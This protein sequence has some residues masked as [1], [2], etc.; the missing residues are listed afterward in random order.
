MTACF[1]NIVFNWSPCLYLVLV[2]F[3]YL[4]FLRRDKYG[5]KV[6]RRSV[7]T[8]AKSV[9]STV[10]VVKYTS[11]QV[12][13]LSCNTIIP[14][15]NSDIFYDLSDYDTALNV[16]LILAFISSLWSLYRFYLCYWSSSAFGT[17]CIHKVPSKH[18]SS[19]RSFCRPAPWWVRLHHHRLYLG[20][21]LSL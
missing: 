4:V 2:S 19:F 7:F 12:F 18:L 15:K 14:N 10:L 1:E 9:R 11:T 8:T 6:Q 13:T 17:I 3:P 5:R 20:G 21:S 16:I